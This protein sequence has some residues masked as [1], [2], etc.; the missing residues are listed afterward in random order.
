MPIIKG[1]HLFAILKD[2]E[3]ILSEAPGLFAGYKRDKIFGRLDCKSGMRMKK[4]N[5]VF[6]HTMEDAIREG[7]R[8]CNNCKPMDDVDF[9]KLMRI[10]PESTLADFY[11]RNKRS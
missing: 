10:I 8:P 2:G 1:K 4:E 7:Y 6:F 11:A 9:Q 3:T 5:R